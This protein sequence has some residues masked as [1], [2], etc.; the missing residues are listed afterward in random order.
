MEK[1]K[2]PHMVLKVKR[3][4][5]I[6]YLVYTESFLFTFPDLRRKGIEINV[7]R[8]A[9]LFGFRVYVC[10]SV[11]ETVHILLSSCKCTDKTQQDR[12]V[13]KVT[14]T[15]QRCIPGLLD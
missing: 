13:R 7:L 14:G 12:L 15:H 5:L 8:R 9:Q 3:K 4:M 10:M 2:Y 1:R 6:S 11:C